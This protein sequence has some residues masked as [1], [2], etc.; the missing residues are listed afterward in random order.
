M[1][2]RDRIQEDIKKRKIASCVVTNF[3]THERVR[4]RTYE[5]QEF[6]NCFGSI[7]WDR[8]SYLLANEVRNLQKQYKCIKT[9][10]N[11]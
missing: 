3:T 5:D 1:D 8:L 6:M 2:D 7:N 9:T 4:F 11:K 10:E